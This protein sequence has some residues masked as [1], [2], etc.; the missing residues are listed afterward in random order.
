MVT[1]IQQNNNR[2]SYKTDYSSTMCL[3]SRVSTPTM[4]RVH[5]SG[6]H[7]GGRLQQVRQWMFERYVFN[8]QRVALFCYYYNNVRQCITGLSNKQRQSCVYFKIVTVLHPAPFH[9]CVKVKSVVWRNKRILKE[10]NSK[11][12]L[13]NDGATFN[14]KET[15]F[16][17]TN[18]VWIWACDNRHFLRT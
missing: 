13:A 18:L 2:C 10:A 9:H 6:I 8:R 11:S 3:S 16:S 7:R 17:R 14:E 12:G 4:G 5:F 15:P 1:V